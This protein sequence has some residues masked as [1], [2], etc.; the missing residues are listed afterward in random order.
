MMLFNKALSI[1]WIPTFTT[2]TLKYNGEIQK[3]KNH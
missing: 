1:H 2:I 3:H